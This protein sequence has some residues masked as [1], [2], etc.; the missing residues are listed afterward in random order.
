MSQFSSKFFSLKWDIHI[1]TLLGTNGMVYLSSHKVH[2]CIAMS[3][4]KFKH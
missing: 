3:D 1:C 2:K 4:S